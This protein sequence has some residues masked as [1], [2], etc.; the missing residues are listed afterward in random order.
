MQTSIRFRIEIDSGNASMQDGNARQELQRILTDAIRFIERTPVL[1]SA[2]CDPE[3][4][5]REIDNYDVR[6]INGNKIGYV[7]VEVQ[8]E[9]E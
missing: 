2:P 1:L 4:N 8:M 7:E 6:D 5:E 9:A 3:E